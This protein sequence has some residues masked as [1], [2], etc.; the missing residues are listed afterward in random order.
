MELC[1]DGHAGVTIVPSGRYFKLDRRKLA[2]SAEHRGLTIIIS[3]SQG[4]NS[5]NRC[6]LFLMNKQLVMM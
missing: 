6:L 3:L 2:K 1:F 5:I 4:I